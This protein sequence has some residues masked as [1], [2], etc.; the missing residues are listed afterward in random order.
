[1]YFGSQLNKFLNFK[2]QDLKFLISQDTYISKYLN[3]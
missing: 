2:I 1:M 3:I